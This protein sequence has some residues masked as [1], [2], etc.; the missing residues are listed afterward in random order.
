MVVITVIAVVVISFKQDFKTLHPD[1]QDNLQA[2]IEK[3][4]LT[5][6]T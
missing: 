2:V 3:D 6:F 5:R 1:D 4:A